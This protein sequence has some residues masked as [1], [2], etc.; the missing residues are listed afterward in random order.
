MY[1]LPC[2]LKNIYSVCFRNYALQEFITTVSTFPAC[3]EI[4]EFALQVLPNNVERYVV[5]S[6]NYIINILLKIVNK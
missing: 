6:R 5:M 2:Y 4:R 1:N 3:D